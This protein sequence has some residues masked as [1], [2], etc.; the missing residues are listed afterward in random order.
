M[1][2][3]SLFLVV[4]GLSYV[5]L[6]VYIANLV[7][8]KRTMRLAAPNASYTDN[9]PQLGL[10]RWMEYGLLFL[11]G[12]TGFS[13]LQLSLFGDL[14]AEMPDLPQLTIST[15]WAVVTFALSTG[16]AI[17]GFMLVYSQ[18]TRERLDRLIGAQGSYNPDSA[19]HT[20]A[21]VLM[22]VMAVST[23]ALFVIQGGISGLAQEL[24]TTSVDGG[25]LI[26]QAVLQ[27]VIALLGVGM[28]IRRSLPDALARLGLRI[29][30]AADIVWGVG[31]GVLFIVISTVGSV[32]WSALTS[33]ELLQEQTAAAE[34]LAQ[35]FTT[36]PLAFLLAATAAIGE[37]IWIRGALQPVFGI[38]ITSVFFAILHTQYTLTPATLIILVVSLGLG[39]LRQRHSTTAAIIAHFVF[40]FIPLALVALGGAS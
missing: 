8:V 34:T 14:A 33:P 32:V 2:F 19:V 31:L 13:V 38:A 18:R 27:V 5:G 15:P 7:E 21:I 20:A 40:N 10:L 29:P 9:S 23:I 30:T 35:A 3:S 11:A 4:F 25:D 6:M 1:D 16:A 26:F 22:L 12:L 17:F 28:A 39:W 37:E 36:L 24:E